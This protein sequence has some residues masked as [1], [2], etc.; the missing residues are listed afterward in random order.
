VV[1]GV[2]FGYDTLKPDTSTVFQVNDTTGV[3]VDSVGTR[4][5][6]RSSGKQLSIEPPY[7]IVLRSLLYP[8]WGQL[9]NRKYFKALAVFTSEATLLGM[10]YTESREAREAY[11]AHLFAPDVATSER[12]YAEYEK[13][14]DRR[15]SLIWWT[16]GLVLFSLADA[17]VDAH[18]LTFEEEFGESQKKGD[19]SITTVGRRDGG[20]VGLK[21][22]F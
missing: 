14:F 12:L 10:I 22:V 6:A 17:Y 20:F 4:V 19:I 18:L 13:H 8:G 5:S 9:C 7:R 16:A 1:A 11:D 15:D 2:S 3:K 21:Y